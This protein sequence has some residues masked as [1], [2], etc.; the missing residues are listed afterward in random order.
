MIYEELSKR[1]LV[2]GRKEYSELIWMRQ[3]KM[4]GK[5]VDSPSYSPDLEEIETLRVG[6]LEFQI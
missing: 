6:M 1:K 4:N 5:V 3:I 2:S